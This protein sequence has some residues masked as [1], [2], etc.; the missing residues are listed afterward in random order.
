MM[1]SVS[2]SET[3]E[4]LE[5]IWPVRQA[6]QEVQ[7]CSAAFCQVSFVVVSEPARA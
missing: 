2:I 1:L 3:N 7:T 4:S 5:A 6:Y